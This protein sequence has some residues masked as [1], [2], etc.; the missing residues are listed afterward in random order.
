M[1]EKVFT[2]QTVL[3]DEAVAALNLQPAGIY[4][5]CTFG[6]GGHSRL[7][8]SRLGPE[9]R[10]LAFDKD[11]QAIVAGQQLTLKDS[12]FMLIHRSFAAL[13]E[14][15]NRRDISKV[16]GILMDLGISSPQ[17]DDGQR[18]FSFRYDAPLDMRMD[19]T[20]GI[21]A[22]QWLASASELEIREVIKTYGEERYA[23][24]IAAAIVAQRCINSLT[25]TRQLAELVARCVRYREPSQ[26]P[27]TRTF[28]AIRIFINQELEDLKKILPQAVSRLEQG[29][30]LVIISFHSL[31]DRIVKQFLLRASTYEKL[32]R[33][34]IVRNHDLAAPPMKRIGKPVRVSAEELRKNPRSRSAILRIGERT[35]GSW[36][37]TG[38]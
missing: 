7:I 37:E 20:Q 24:K 5:D 33:W 21:T 6:R 15:L 9:G 4:I 14:E 28:Q 17:I 11:P 30:R 1:S 31:E 8:L 38:L 19:P 34:V 36:R 27:A 13:D 12:R 16:S 2:H 3:L 25:T 10:L 26:D 22:A 23:N 29:G 32:P 18:G 35:A